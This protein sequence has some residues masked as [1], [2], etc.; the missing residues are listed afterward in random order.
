MA[1]D[2]LPLFEYAPSQ[3]WIAVGAGHMAAESTRHTVP[4]SY[5]VNQ[6]VEPTGQWRGILAEVD[7]IL[8]TGRNETGSQISGPSMLEVIWWYLDQTHRVAFQDP[9]CAVS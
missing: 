5:S 3:E 4:C 9:A 1:P 7:K 2:L 6:R 8:D